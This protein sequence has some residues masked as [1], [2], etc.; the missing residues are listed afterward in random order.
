MKNNIQAGN[1]THNLRP[2]LVI[3][4]ASAE[5]LSAILAYNVIEINTI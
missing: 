2:H 3:N 5:S 1:R 4:K